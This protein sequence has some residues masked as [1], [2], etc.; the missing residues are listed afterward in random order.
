MGSLRLNAERITDMSVEL[1]DV[2]AKVSPETLAVLTSI[3]DAYEKDLSEFIR[4]ILSDRAE[5]FLRA[6]RLADKRM[7][8]EGGSGILGE[9]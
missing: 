6:A 5:R 8:V 3:A 1:K 4:E 7:K 2:R 9:K